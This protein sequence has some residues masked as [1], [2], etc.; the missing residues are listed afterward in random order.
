MLEKICNKSLSLI[1]IWSLSLRMVVD[2]HQNI[3]KS[4]VV[5][6]RKGA[7][8]LHKSPQTKLVEFTWTGFSSL[9]QRS[10]KDFNLGEIIWSLSLIHL[11]SLSLRPSNSCGQ[12]PKQYFQELS[13]ARALANCKLYQKWTIVV[14][15]TGTDAPESSRPDSEILQNINN[16]DSKYEPLT[17]PCQDL[18]RSLSQRTPGSVCTKLRTVLT[19]SGQY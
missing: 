15:F 16:L 17:P 6:P 7:C 4:L 9:I 5:D 3:L 18:S 10:V 8:K 14:N 1:H 11:Q 19:N 2:S 13:L 12:S